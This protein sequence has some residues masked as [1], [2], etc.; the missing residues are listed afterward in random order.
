MGNFLGNLK[1]FCKKFFCMTNTSQINEEH[2]NKQSLH[3]P[4]FRTA[5]NSRDF[6]YKSDLVRN[7]KLSQNSESSKSSKKFNL[8]DDKTKNFK[9]SL[10]DFEVIKTLGKGSF[11]K[12]LLAKS[13]IDHLYYAMKV[14]K[15]KMLEQKKQINHTRTEREILEKIKHPFIVRLFFAFQTAEKLYLI[16]EFIPGGEIFYHLRRA[17][18]FNEERTKFYICEIVLALEYLHR[19]N[20]I[21]RDLKPENVLLSKDGHIKLTDFGLSKILSTNFEP[22]NEMN[23]SSK[24]LGIIN[25]YTSGAQFSHDSEPSRAYTICGTPEYLAPEI[26]LGKG[27]NKS[28]D[29]WSLGAL[30]Y[31]MLVGHSPF[32]ENKHKLDIKTYYK[33]I[34]PHKNISKNALDL[35]KKLLNTDSSQRLGSSEKD[36]EEIKS[37]PFFAGVNWRGVIEGS[38]RSPFIPLL[39]HSE[40]LSNFD[41]NFTKEDPHSIDNDRFNLFPSNNY[42]TSESQTYLDFSY[43]HKDFN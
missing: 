5:T 4:L 26:L 24:N 39:R 30:M 36:A 42:K 43:I 8:L 21:Y 13:N 23:S 20:I 1:E 34:E 10:R 7:R 12:V 41:S 38:I 29:W 28:I 2:V 17:G 9:I 35:I 37:H 14:L 15:K 18:C 25:K 6:Q 31:E 22:N 19:K 32:K 11:G 16:T 3:D 40:D 27:Y 33:V